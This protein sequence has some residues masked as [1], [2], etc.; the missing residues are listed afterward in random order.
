MKKKAITKRRVAARGKQVAVRRK[1]VAVPKKPNVPMS[2]TAEVLKIISQAVSNPDLDAV[3]LESLINMYDRIAAQKA[4]ASFISALADMQPKLPKITKKGTTGGPGKQKYALWEDINQEITPTLSEYGFALTFRLDPIP[5]GGL[6][7]TGVLSHRDGHSTEN[8]V[9]LPFDTSG[10]KN[11]V[12]SVGSTISYGKRYAAIL[13][14]NITT[15]GEDDD[16]SGA[17]AGA[18]TSGKQT[19]ITVKQTEE[20]QNLID[21]TDTN[22]ESFCKY[23]NVDAVANMTAADYERAIDGF[24]A[25]K[26]VKIR[27]PGLGRSRPLDAQNE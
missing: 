9:P 7:V 12:Q 24:D 27:P 25:K 23:M 16:G 22:I 4:K 8:A 2:E 15:C 3:K 18:T 6:S 1:Q 5:D 21:E 13:I 20:I 19:K 10:V 14:L 11:P 17:G 26:Q